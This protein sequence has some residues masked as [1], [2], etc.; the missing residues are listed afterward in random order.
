MKRYALLLLVLLSPGCYLGQY[1]LGYYTPDKTLA[2]RNRSIARNWDWEGKQ[3]ADDVDHALLLEPMG[4]LTKWN[5][6]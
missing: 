5:L 6:R 4:H 2:E 3:F 1:D